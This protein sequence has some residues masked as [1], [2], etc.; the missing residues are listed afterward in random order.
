MSSKLLLAGL[1]LICAGAAGP[2]VPLACNTRAFT[3]AERADWRKRLE[4]V[5]GSVTAARD[6]PDGYS[7]EID[8]RQS[9]FVEVARWVE[10]ER[11]CC[12]FFIFELGMRGE[13]GNIWLNLRGREGVKEFIASDFHTLFEHLKSTATRAK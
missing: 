13:N 8:P 3:A 7:L 5:M 4:Q 10:L 9:S 6:L 11:K 2:P 12:P 1:A